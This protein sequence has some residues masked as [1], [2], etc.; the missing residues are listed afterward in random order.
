MAKVNNGSVVHTEEITWISQS[1]SAQRTATLRDTTS[2]A[3]RTLPLT[4]LC[5]HRVVG[6]AKAENTEAIKPNG[7]GLRI[8][9]PM[10]GVKA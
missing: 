5:L 4:G 8:W 2:G 7:A 9:E 1:N 3:M 6:G 10:E